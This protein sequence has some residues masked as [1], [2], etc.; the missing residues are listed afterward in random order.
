MR[1]PAVLPIDAIAV[2]RGEPRGISALPSLLSGF[3]AAIIAIDVLWFYKAADD[4]LT[5][6]RA[7]EYDATQYRSPDDGAG[8]GRYLCN[9][10]T[11]IDG[12]VFRSLPV[13]SRSSATA[14]SP[15]SRKRSNP[16]GTGC[17]SGAARTSSPW[18]S[19][20]AGYTKG[21]AS[22]PDHDRHVLDRSRRA[23]HGDGRGHGPRQPLPILISP[24]I[25][26]R[27]ACPIR[28]SSRSSISTTRPPP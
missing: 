25:P 5:A 3:P 13:D 26:S 2:F 15:V 16:S 27:T 28:S 14:T 4:R 22:P 18:P 11:I 1:K 20:A 19:A 10:H 8:L 17:P 12:G 9:Q 21:Q 23:Q 24:A 7:E 6:L